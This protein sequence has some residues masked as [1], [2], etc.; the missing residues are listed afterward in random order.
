MS[1][2]PGKRVPSFCAAAAKPRDP[3]FGEKAEA[4]HILPGSYPVADGLEL[5]GTKIL[6]KS[7][8]KRSGT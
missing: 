3:T 7:G 1:V 8:K 5:P 6:M 2:D 4:I